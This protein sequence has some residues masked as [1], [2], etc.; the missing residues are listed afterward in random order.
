MAFIIGDAILKPL[1]FPVIIGLLVMLILIVF[2]ALISGSEIAF[3]SL[4]PAQLNSI[5]SEKNKTNKLIISLLEI[6][7]RLLATI[8][9]AN[10]F[11]NVAIIILSTFILSNLLNLA[12]Y[13]ALSF[14]IQVII[15][16]SLILILGEIMPKI[17]SAFKPVKFAAFMVRP[18]K[19]LITIFYPL[20][21]ILVRSSN[22]ID[23]RLIKKGTQISMSELSE[24]I[25]ITSDENTPE[26]ERKIL[27][28]IVK[29][30]DIDVKE[31]MK[32]RVDITAV[33]ISTKYKNLLKIILNCGYSRIPAYKESLDKISGILYVKDLLSHLAKDDDF[34]WPALLRPAFFVPENKKINDLLQ[35]FQEKKIHLA[36]VVDEYGG[37][38]GIVTLEDI[39][40][41]IVGEISD[42][43]DILEDE[44]DYSKIDDRN[45][46]FEGKTSLNDFCKILDIEDNIFDE[47]KGESETLAGL[48][49][50]LEG[51]IP[52]VGENTKY[53]NF[54]FS[55][56]KADKRRI[57]QV[58]VKIQDK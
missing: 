2:S 11:V 3:F 18:I 47:V 6:P 27:K 22:L 35:E 19:V 13:P 33:N 56:K 30:R 51:K 58:H 34:N 40:E 28:G 5:R 36:I 8:L 24:A 29:F 45:Y 14:I 46:L 9:I 57:E 52:A 53:L 32:S 10:N 17:Y 7:K 16:T 15:I 4:S 41:E 1:S 38:S 55:V 23:K 25:E 26:E 50:E 43:F 20:S 54:E 42:E 44:I 39:I 37:T 31:I 49:L 21:S 12:D 48:I